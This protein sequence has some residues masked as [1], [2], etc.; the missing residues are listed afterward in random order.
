MKKFLSTALT[1]LAAGSLA[2][3]QIVDNSDAVKGC[4][5]LGE[6][7]AGNKFVQM[8]RATVEESIRAEAKALQA[9]KVFLTVVSH[10]H[11]KLGKQYT[12]RA[13]AWKCTP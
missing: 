9:D 3:L 2:A 1:V 12:A 10:N 7:N 8:D 5:R 11:P 13:T 4:Q 6:I